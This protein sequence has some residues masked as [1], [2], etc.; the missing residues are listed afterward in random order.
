MHNE[1][2]LI[3]HEEYCSG[4]YQNVSIIS[5]KYYAR[6]FYVNG[7]INPNATYSDNY[8]R[9]NKIGKYAN[10]GSSSSSSESSKSSGIGLGAAVGGGVV[11]L[12]KWLF[13]ETEEEKAQQAKE[14]E[15]EDI[16][17]YRMERFDYNLKKHFPLKGTT[18]ELIARATALLDQSDNFRLEESNPDELHSR[19]AE[20]KCESVSNYA[21]KIC[22]QIRKQDPERFNQPDMQEL[23]KRVS[24]RST[25]GKVKIFLLVW[26]ILM[27]V[28]GLLVVVLV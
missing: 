14:E 18:D 11:G 3:S 20:E 12:A 25:W 13:T 24:K 2:V 6:M 16:V 19:L 22:K 10:G 21:V 26:L 7:E 23:F 27:V 8:L 9:K 1:D 28:I 15:I 4:K 17:E 5:G